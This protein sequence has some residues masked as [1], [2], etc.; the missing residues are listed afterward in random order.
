MEKYTKEQLNAM[1]KEAL[2]QLLYNTQQLLE[3]LVKQNQEL[4]ETIALMNQRQFGRKSEKNLVTKDQITIFDMGVNEAE[5]TASGQIPM[6]PPMETVVVQEHKRAKKKGKREEDLSRYPVTIVRHDLDDAE[7]REKFPEGYT[8]LPDEVYKKL[9]VQPATFIVKE[10]H[11]T[12]YKGKNGKIVKG[13]HPKEMLSNSIASPS[14]VAFIMNAK[15]TNAVPLYRQEQELE[16][17]DI[18]ISRQNMAHGVITAAERY[19]SL[20]W[21]RLKK[22]ITSCSVVHADE[23]PVFVVKDGREGMHKSYMWVYRNGG[24]QDDHP[25]VLYDF[26]LTRKKEAPG[27]FL[28]AFTGTLVTDGYQVYHSL[29]KD[30]ETQFKV[31]GCWAHY[32]R[33]IVI[34]GE[35]PTSA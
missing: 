17:N 12:V 4:T 15:Y 33:S 14:L 34:L 5:V 2:I 6:E 32:P 9:E 13:K 20:L 25:V 8:T 21:D 19:L 11:I 31:A 30:T 1:D 35:L 22:E 16:R 29:E 28:D 26:Q 10:H 18:R 24:L 7:L 3:T 27:K 23:T